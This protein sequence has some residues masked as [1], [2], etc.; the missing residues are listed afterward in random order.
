MVKVFIGN[1]KRRPDKRW[2]TFGAM[3]SR[4]FKEGFDFEFVESHDSNQYYLFEDQFEAF[5]KRWDPQ[6]ANNEPL[7]L[8]HGPL[9]GSI[10]TYL[11]ILEKIIDSESPGVLMLDDHYLVNKIPLLLVRKE[12][13]PIILNLTDKSK[14]DDCLLFHPEAAKDI[15]ESLL[16]HQAPQS[17]WLWKHCL[18]YY[19]YQRS[20][21]PY[22]FHIG[23][24]DTFAS[25]IK[26]NNHGVQ[27]GYRNLARAIGLS[28]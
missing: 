8:E 4:G 3:T 6:W 18:K 19:N 10:Y 7:D 13:N 23:P 21:E 9:L 28:T 20:S 5:C 26:E 1:L 14:S 24:K 22:A 16:I 17:L 2:A 25:D 11:E 15:S 27:Q 12:D